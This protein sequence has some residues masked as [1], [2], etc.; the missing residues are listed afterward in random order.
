MLF[1]VML[2]AE[3]DDVVIR[4]RAAGAFRPNVGSVGGNL[5]ANWAWGGTLESL[6]FFHFGA[7]IVKHCP[8]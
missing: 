4:P 3:L 5:I 8:G 6:D 2:P 1:T 7:P